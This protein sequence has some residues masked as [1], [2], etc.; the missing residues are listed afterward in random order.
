MENM[1]TKSLFTFLFMVTIYLTLA[2][3]NV[4][5]AEE[6]I[7]VPVY[8]T[9]KHED[10]TELK[11]G[12]AY[13]NIKPGD[14][15]NITAY[16]NNKD[17]LY[18]SQNLAFMDK[19][20]YKKNEKGMALINYYYADKDFKKETE[21][22]STAD[23]TSAVL[24]IPNFKPGTRHVLCIEGIAAVDNWENH[25]AQTGWVNIYFTVPSTPVQETKITVSATKV[26]DTTA[27][28]TATVTGSTFSKFLYHWDNEA[29]KT[30][31]T[32]NQTVTIP[33]TPGDHILTVKAVAADG[34]TA[35][36]T[37]KVT[38]VAPVVTK[39]SVVA[40]KINDTSAKMTATVTG[41]TFSKFLYHWDNEADKTSTINPQT[42]TI[43]TAAGTHTLTVKAIAADGKTASTTLKVTVVAKPATD[44]AV[45]VSKISDTSAKMIATV[46]GSTF[47]KF[48]YHWDN[49]TDLIST[50]NPTEVAIPT[51]P[52]AH[53][54]TVKVIAADGK[55]ATGILN[56]TVA[57]PE[58]PE[59][60]NGSV[61][62]KLNGN[63]LYNNSLSRV[64]GN[65]ILNILGTPSA[66]F[67]TIVYRW[68]DGD[69]KEISGSVANIKVL[70]EEGVTHTLKVYGIL[71]DGVK[72]NTKTY[73]FV[74]EEDD[75]LIIEPWM[76]EDSDAEGLIVSLRNDTEE[77]KA[78]K[79][80]Y[81]LDEEIIYYV[82]YKNCGKDIENKVTL[83]LNIPLKFEVINSAAGLISQTEKTI[84]WT[85][86]EGLE[87]GA[88]GTK[89]VVV[90]Y[91]QLSKSSYT[92]EIVCPQANILKD[93]K[94]MDSS[95]VINYIYLNGSTE[96]Q[97]EHDPY[98][99]GDKE[100]PTFR[101]DSTITRAEGA[102]VLTRIFGIKISSTNITTKYSDINQTYP[103]AQKAITAA[104]D[105]GIINGYEDGTYR[106]NNKMTRA[107]FMKI[108]ASYIDIAGSKAGVKGLEVKEDANIKVYKNPY[109]KNHWAVDYITL[110]VRLNMTSVSENDK[111]LR[112]ND[113]ITR[114]EVAQLVN[115]FSLRA[116][117]KTTT[118][119][120]T[121]FIDVSRTHPLY[122]DIVEAT[123]D[124]HK[125]CITNDGKES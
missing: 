68:D 82:D 102:L 47:S 25:E 92:Y 19:Y 69:K 110:L 23:P 49:E 22:K 29:D 37:L 97:D 31:T 35:S 104:T 55:T 6:K 119:T 56:V 13:T 65:E 106:P 86:E 62:V 63:T 12:K 10:G 9:V 115:Y 111:N 17:S 2:F 116:P 98:M 52:G 67:E 107:E 124:T 51:T 94:R 41:S 112:L 96:I 59:K 99:F 60:L 38:V 48:L 14:K 121:Q 76:R 36:T 70:A 79:N 53:I 105:L 46:T 50:A 78:N 45:A 4:F 88:S 21:I 24:T 16:C 89:V 7:Y 15:I 122:E 120:K 3:G 27:K 33:T 95:A 44:I 100:K 11:G 26:N 20:G 72:T 28:M 125:Y 58:E 43:P 101:P 114:A 66:N 81:K 64:E 32:N 39:I 57:E 117:A 90:K 74:I 1:K 84:T 109:D 80:F 108:I 54:L 91:T 75:E 40:T 18:W 93:S 5:A 71:K 83:V 118:A 61:N 103:E 8:M 77:D 123:R 87:K 73:N 30:S 85:F 34:K 42:V 113:Q